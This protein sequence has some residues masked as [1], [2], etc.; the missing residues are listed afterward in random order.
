M[1]AVPNFK[2]IGSTQYARRDHL[3]IE[4]GDSKQPQYEHQVKF[5]A[6]NNESN[7]SV[8]A[9][10]GEAVFN[11]EDGTLKLDTIFQSAVDVPPNN[12]MRFSVQSKN[13]EFHYQPELTAQEILDDHL[14]P[15]R[16]V[17]SYA[18][19]TTKRNGKYK[20]GKLCHIYRPFV[21]DAFGAREWCEMDI[22]G[23]ML[24][25]TLPAAFM[26]SAVY[27]VTL[28]PDFGYTTVGGTEELF[29]IGAD[30]RAIVH[31]DA[32]RNAYDGDIVTQVSF[33]MRPF[34]AFNTILT[35]MAIYDFAGGVPVNKV[36][37][38]LTRNAFTSNGT[39]QW[40][41]IAVGNYALVAGT[42]YCVTVGEFG[43][44]S[45]QYIPYDNLGGNRGIIA[46]S[47]ALNDP[48]TGAGATAYQTS[49]YATF[50]EGT[51]PAAG[52]GG[53]KRLLMGVG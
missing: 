16:V 21:V 17:G 53:S 19:Y 13:V 20:A 10:D 41:N 45:H 27:P 30:S 36:G 18:V 40:F 15:E 34:A 37:A 8:R 22:N 7:F 3:N 5:M 50:T 14:R 33:S 25:V 46:S 28:D 4:I 12:V 52:G 24:A 23:G 1:R 42:D 38:N 48:W 44:T 39:Q 35:R 32:L 26:S 9:L 47:N 2:S 29:L 49:I 31:A 43:G 51:P 6:W 11:E